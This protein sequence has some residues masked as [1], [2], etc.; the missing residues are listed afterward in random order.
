MP[1]PRCVAGV[2]RVADIDC[3][4][5]RQKLGQIDILVNSAGVNV[6]KRS[7]AELSPEDWN[8]LMSVNATGA[9]NT[10]REILPEM[11]ARGDGLI[12]NISSISGRIAFSPNSAYCSS[13]HAVPRHH[14]G[15]IISGACLT[16]FCTFL[17]PCIIFLKLVLFKNVARGNVLASK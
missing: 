17:R 1:S 9:F 16:Y 4:R 2:R 7:M 8:Q 14:H 3:Q 15:S 5:A 10:I 11:R 6:V 13:K 12:I